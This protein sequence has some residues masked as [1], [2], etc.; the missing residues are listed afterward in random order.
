M[1]FDDKNF[2]ADNEKQIITKF[3]NDSFD[4]EDENGTRH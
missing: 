4:Y 2:G 3:V 1:K